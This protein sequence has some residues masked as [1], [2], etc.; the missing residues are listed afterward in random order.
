MGSAVVFVPGFIMGA[1]YFKSDDVGRLYFF[2]DVALNNNLVSLICHYV[3]D[4]C[5]D[6]GAVSSNVLLYILLDG[7]V[8]KDWC[9]RT[10]HSIAHGLRD[11]YGVSTKQMLLTGMGTRRGCPCLRSS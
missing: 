8:V 3:A 9:N 5:M 1:K 2:F 7:G 4:V 11:V 6:E 10:F